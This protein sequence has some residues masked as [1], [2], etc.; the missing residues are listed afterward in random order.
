MTTDQS[1][2]LNAFRAFEHAGWQSAAAQYGEEFGKLT[3]TRSR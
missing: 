2:D 3:S 1:V